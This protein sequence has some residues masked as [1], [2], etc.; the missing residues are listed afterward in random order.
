MNT[1]KK[2]S[3]GWLIVISATMMILGCAVI[4]QIN[5]TA[6][7]STSLESQSTETLVSMVRSLNDY[8]NN[9]ESEL[10]QLNI[11]NTTLDTSATLERQIQQLE[12][13]TGAI[14]VQG[15][16]VSITITGDYDIYNFDIIDILN[17]LKVTGAEAMAVNNIRYTTTSRLTQEIDLTG[18]IYVAMD[19]ERLL[20][21][22]V[23]TAI[24]DP[25]TLEKGLTF[26]GGIIDNLNTL[27][28][29][30]PIVRQETGIVIPAATIN[31]NVLKLETVTN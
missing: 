22:I 30:Y 31:T 18:Q 23:I 1:E 21:P 24:G 8:R 29:I 9:L 2:N 26:T 15:D 12:I 28:S 3:S 11:I 13:F 25:S 4:M 16:G 7:Q 27:Y 17:E 19:G 10:D 20:T 14:A 5:A 6:V